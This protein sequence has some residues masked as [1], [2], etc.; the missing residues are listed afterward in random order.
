MSTTMSFSP[1]RKSQTTRKPQASGRPVKEAST[2]PP[3]LA[4]HLLDAALTYS[5]L[6][7]RIRNKT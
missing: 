4:V 5:L 2:T 3:V 6:M 1:K 7:I